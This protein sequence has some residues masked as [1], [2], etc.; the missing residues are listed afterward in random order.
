M[1]AAR[2]LGLFAPAPEPAPKPTPAAL[3]DATLDRHATNHAQA[4]VTAP[5]VVEEMRARGDGW[6]LTEERRWLG[7][8]LLPSRGWER[9][10]ELVR[11]GS[12][13]RP[14]PVWRRAR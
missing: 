3:R 8:V 7:A 5:E 10:G 13:G 11:T 14:V 1:T 4:T 12:R 2:Q 6:M 9:T